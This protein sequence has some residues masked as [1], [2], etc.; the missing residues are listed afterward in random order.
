MRFSVDELN[1]YRGK[2]AKHYCLPR[3]FFIK[4]ARALHFPSLPN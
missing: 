1:L 3:V 4:F 2:Q